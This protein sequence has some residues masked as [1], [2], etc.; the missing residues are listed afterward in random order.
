LRS[1]NLEVLNISLGEDAYSRSTVSIN[2][3]TFSICTI[4]GSGKSENNV[5]LADI[6]IAMGCDNFALI[7]SSDTIVGCISNCDSSKVID[8][9]TSCNGYGT[10]CCQTTIPLDLDALETIIDPIDISKPIAS[11]PKNVFMIV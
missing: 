7:K 8:A 11:P 6:F 9:T 5:K 4:D 10:Y 3:Q 2:Y 1:L